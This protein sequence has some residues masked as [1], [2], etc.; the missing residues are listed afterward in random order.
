M[1]SVD[2]VSMDAN[3]FVNYL[4]QYQKQ[5]QAKQDYQR[6]R[7]RLGIRTGTEIIKLFHAQLNWAWNFNCSLKLQCWKIKIFLALKLSCDVF[8]LFLNVKMSTF[9][10]RIDNF[11]LRWVEHEKCFITWGLAFR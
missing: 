3:K 1:E 7:V 9:M 4:R 10:S 5:Q 11:M 6:K 8:I 2:E